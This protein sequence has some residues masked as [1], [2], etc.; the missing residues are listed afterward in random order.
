MSSALASCTS[1]MNWVIQTA[2]CIQ[3]AVVN[4]YGIE[5]GMQEVAHEM[6]MQ[7]VQAERHT[8]SHQMYHRTR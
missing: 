6:G 3:H 1:R 2:A 5:R 7:I 8:H 4:G